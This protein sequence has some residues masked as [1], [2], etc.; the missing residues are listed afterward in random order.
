MFADP[1]VWVVL[2]VIVLGALFF[3]LKARDSNPYI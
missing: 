3:Y 2:G 1:V